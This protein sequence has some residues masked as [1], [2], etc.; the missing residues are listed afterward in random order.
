MAESVIPIGRDLI[1]EMFDHVEHED[2]G[3]DKHQ[4]YL[5]L[6]N[7]LEHEISTFS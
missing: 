1:Q 5:S 7:A 6:A 2:I 3:V 4:K